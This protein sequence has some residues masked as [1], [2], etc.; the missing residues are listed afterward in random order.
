MKTLITSLTLTLA[1]S[2]FAATPIQTLEPVLVHEVKGFLNLMPT[3]GDNPN[4]AGRGVVT[5]VATVPSNGCTSGD[6]FEA[7]FTSTSQGQLLTIVRTNPDRCRAFLPMGVQVEI[8]ATGFS[9]G[10]YVVLVNPI[11]TNVQVVH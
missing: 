4:A 10:L 6:D 3:I 5:V 9:S 7:N 11:K 8:R 2:A 1:S